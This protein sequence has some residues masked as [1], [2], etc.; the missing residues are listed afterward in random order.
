[1]TP[2]WRAHVFV[3][4]GRVWTPDER[5]S[6]SVL[7]PQSTAFRFSIG[8]GLSYQTPVGGLGLYLGY[9]L[10]PS[11]VDVRDPGKVLDAFQA[12]T[13]IDSVET[14]WIRRFHLH[15]SFGVAL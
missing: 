8:T 15:L 14:E 1:M 3:D 6:Q 4:G 13:P 12:G 7:L 10:N 11:S 9:K 5:F 2:A